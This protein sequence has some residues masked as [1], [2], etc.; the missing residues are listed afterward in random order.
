MSCTRQ[1][2]LDAISR[3]RSGTDH[4]NLLLFL[5]VLQEF[6]QIV[7]DFAVVVFA[8]QVKAREAADAAARWTREM[9]SGRRRDCPSRVTRSHRQEIA[10]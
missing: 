9:A 5:D 3:K 2:G 10:S 1:I 6:P 8:T 4:D 7:V